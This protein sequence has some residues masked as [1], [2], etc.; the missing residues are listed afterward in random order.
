VDS[1][2]VLARIEEGLP[3]VEAIARGMSRQFGRYV[4]Y[5]DLVSQGRE[6]LLQAARTFDPD[7]GVPFPRW[8][9]LRVRGAMLDGTRQQ[10]NLP[11]RVY[12][13]LRAAQAMDHIEEAA[14]EEAPPATPEAADAALGEQLSSAAMAAALA[15]LGMRSSDFIADAQDPDH[16]PESN[17]G[18]AQMVEFVRSAIATRPEQEQALL[19]R[20]YF[21]EV[22]IEEA[23]REMGLSK[24]WGSRLHA[25]AIEGLAKTM[26]R[27]RVET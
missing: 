26:K 4:S 22:T 27:T 11:R 24:S 20:V 8:A 15:F 16:S 25:R 19:R 21:D 12:R 6:T 5:E 23:A 1:P 3:V 18:Y 13:K 17:V 2:Q 9:A 7:R 10:G 14:Q